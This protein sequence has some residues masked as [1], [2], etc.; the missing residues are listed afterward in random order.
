M[1]SFEINNNNLEINF[2]LNGGSGFDVDA[3]T[4]P[5]AVEA[6]AAENYAMIK[7]FNIEDLK[8]DNDGTDAVAKVDLLKA[9][10]E[11]KV[12]APSGTDAAAKADAGNW[13]YYDE[14]GKL[15]DATWSDAAYVDIN[16]YQINALILR[17]NLNEEDN[18]ILMGLDNSK[19]VVVDCL[20]KDNGLLDEGSALVSDSDCQKEVLTLLPTLDSAEKVNEIAT[21]LGPKVLV[22]LLR[23]IRYQGVRQDGLTVPQPYED[24][25]AATEDD[26]KN[27]ANTSSSE[28]VALPKFANGIKNVVSHV[29]A[30]NNLWYINKH[31][32]PEPTTADEATG[33]KF[34]EIEATMRDLEY[35]QQVIK[36]RHATLK[37]RIDGLLGSTGLSPAMNIRIQPT[38]GGSYDNFY[39]ISEEQFKGG[40]LPVG[41]PV[42][43]VTSVPSVMEDLEKMVNNLKKKLTNAGKPLTKSSEASITNVIKEMKEKEAKLKKMVESF[44]NMLADPNY[45]VSGP[46]ITQTDIEKYADK[47]QSGQS[48]MIP[49]IQTLLSAYANSVPPSVPI[50]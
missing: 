9:I 33:V 13:P 50:H 45:V 7:N 26:A 47:V 8:D 49:V 44:Q 36:E 43:L 37:L 17:D 25:L 28:H 42:N 2:K 4:V 46:G 10:R 11:G 14:D 35:Y 31:L 18:L 5:P 27:G 3:I 20:Q 48:K 34:N 12:D 22:N 41:I 39:Y 6:V 30:R 29:S 19:G 24:W 40:A 1:F 23:A 21:S 15:A 16:Q 32:K 38:T